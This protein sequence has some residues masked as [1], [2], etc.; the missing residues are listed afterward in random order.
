[1]TTLGNLYSKNIMV[2]LTNSKSNEDKYKL[3]H[4]TVDYQITGTLQSHKTE[5]IIKL[6]DENDPFFLYSLYMTEEDFQTLKHQQG[7][8]VDFSSF[9]QRF[10]DLLFACEKDVSSDNPKFQ[11]QLFT[12]EPLPFDHTNASLNIIEIN[13]FKHLVHLSLSFMPGNDSDV[14][15]Y[16]ATCLKTLKEE[17]N[18]LSKCSDDTR[19]Q[20]NQKLESTQQVKNIKNFLINLF[21]QFVKQY[22]I[23]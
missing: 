6:T 7:L 5:L 10:I 17:Y 19:L 20:L 3:I 9:G 15:K 18:K 21:N 4:V 8:L 1:M 23:I 11:L 13:P 16:L 14:K 2:R 22:L 12:K